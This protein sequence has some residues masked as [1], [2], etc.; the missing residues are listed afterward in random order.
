MIFLGISYESI[1]NMPVSRRKKLYDKFR[2]FLKA[3]QSTG[4]GF[5]KGSVFPR[6]KR[7]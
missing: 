1:M 4:G 3:Q 7:R 2:K 5:G 6:G